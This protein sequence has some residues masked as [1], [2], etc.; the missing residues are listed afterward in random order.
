MTRVSNSDSDALARDST[1]QRRCV[2]CYEEIHRQARVC[3]ACDSYQDWRRH[4]QVGSSVL[5]LLVALVSVVAL[6]VPVFKPILTTYRSN[7]NVSY[8]GATGEKFF[9]VVSNG[10]NKPGVIGRIEAGVY[11]PPKPT[12]DPIFVTLQ[13]RP[14]VIGPGETREIEIGVPADLARENFA[15][16]LRQIANPQ[17]PTPVIRLR[18]SIIEFNHDPKAKY[19]ED[20]FA[21]L[22]DSSFVRECVASLRDKATG[23]SRWCGRA[24]EDVE[25]ALAKNPELKEHVARRGLST[26]LLKAEYVND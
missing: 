24:L 17:I 12:T 14:I 8:Q 16:A 20:S 13:Q 6:S 4:L 25:A 1:P 3:V 23:E 21:S 18:A 11:Y 9:F 10:G 15:E 5:A 2:S 7:L 19:F 22:W 26:A